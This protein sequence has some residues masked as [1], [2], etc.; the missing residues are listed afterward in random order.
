MA[1]E[2]DFTDSN[3]GTITVE[4]NSPNTETS[5]TLIGRNYTDYGEIFNENFLH[6]LENFANNTS[7]INPVEGQLWYDTTAGVD[8]LKVYDGTGWVAAGG[9]KKAASQPEA[10]A[11]VIGDL[12]VDTSN[13]Q[14]FLYSGSGWILVGPEYAAGASTG[15]KL[16]WIVSTSP[17]S[18][19][20]TALG[21]P[22]I[23]NYSN[24]VPISIISG[25]TFTPKRAITGFS[26]IRAGVNISSNYKFYGNSEKAEN[27]IVSG[28]VYPGSEFARLNSYNIFSKSLRITDG[29]GLTIGESQTLTVSTTGSNVNFV[30]KSTDGSIN[31]KVALNTTAIRATA[32][33]KIG[34]FNTSPTEALDITGNLKASGTLATGAATFSGNVSL[35]GDLTANGNAEIDGTLTTGSIYRQ[36][37]SDVIGT[38]V[39]P[40]NTA[41]ITSVNAST[42]TANNIVGTVT[43]T[44]T[45]AA[46]LTQSTTF[47]LTGDIISPG[48]AFDGT[49]NV[50]LTTSLDDSYFSS[51]DEITSQ[52][53]GGR[54]LA[55]DEILIN[56]TVA[57]PTDSGST[58]GLHRI[59]QEDFLA[60]IDVFQPGMI[61]PYGGTTAPD[62]WLMCDGS[63]YTRAGQYAALYSVIGTS[64]GS[65]TALT[66]RVPDFRGRFPLGYLAGETRTIATDEDRVYDDGAAD[67]LGAD[68]GSNRANIT[69][70]NLP[71][72]EHMLMGDAGTQYYAVTNVTG[73]SDTN[74]TGISI[75]G[76]NTGT[77][78]TVSGGIEGYT[79]QDKF[80]TVPPFTTVNYIIYAGA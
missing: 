6:L 20:D 26:I 40:F 71:D 72:H 19:V 24:N 53:V 45:K 10:S 61:M 67:I 2:V 33:G 47:Q 48:V 41:Y 46:S 60:T 59:T 66:F 43:G 78:L 16:E 14:V 34:I 49:S 51:K 44:A 5:L 75:V 64:Y 54:V 15:A 18:D 63:S 65:P 42:I 35:T 74:S 76:G 12:W 73:V 52:Y 25:V 56:R 11:S 36:T 77:G 58:T 17:A 29:A 3:K 39:S 57:D 55:T 23:V 30:N 32:D 28:T 80:E 38:S 69:V 1:Y 68:G 79:S 70:S 21:N 22:C 37:S 8:Q 50:T 62:K 13:Q 9:L 31:F 27:L 7:P 4:D